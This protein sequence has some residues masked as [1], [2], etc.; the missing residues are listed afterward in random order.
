MLSKV[1]EHLAKQIP[2]GKKKAHEYEAAKLL[3]LKAADL[4]EFLNP[5][6]TINRRITV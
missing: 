6:T 5:G 2:A 3:G 1:E 4:D